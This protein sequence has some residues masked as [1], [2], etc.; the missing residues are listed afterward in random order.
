MINRSIAPGLLVLALACTAHA[1]EDGSVAARHTAWRGCL[2]EVFA[3]QT[4]LTSRTFAADGAL[5]ACREPEGAYLAA[6]A[7][8]P[9]LDGEDVARVRPAL[10]ERAKD[11]L[12]G[13][14]VSRPL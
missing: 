13:R 4:A 7:S 10:I 6:L 9:L 5:R 12:L 3:A 11:W 2:H 8:S 1:E 14:T